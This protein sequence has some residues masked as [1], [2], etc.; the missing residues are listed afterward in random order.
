MTHADYQVIINEPSKVVFDF[1]LDGLNN[2]KWRSAV[3][4]IS[5]KNGEAGSVGAEYRQSLKGPGGRK[6]DGD[7]RLVTV[8]PNKKLAFEVTTGPARP[9]GEYLL[10]E[11]G[12]STTLSFAMDY[13]TKGFKKLIDPMITKTMKSEVANLDVL[14][15]VLEQS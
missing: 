13:Q 8:E 2:P 7:Y 10:T 1:L 11:S 5:L 6:I 14:K 15:R 4:D 12:G 9:T 3:V